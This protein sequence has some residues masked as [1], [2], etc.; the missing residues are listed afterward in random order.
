MASSSKSF[1]PELFRLQRL[2]KFPK[3]K[4]GA[5]ERSFRV[6]WCNKYPWLHYDKASD[7]AFCHLCMRAVSEGKLLA[8]TKR[9]SAFI[10][11]G[12][13]YWKE[14]TTAFKKHQASAC[15]REAHEALIMLPQQ[16][17]GDIGELLSQKHLDQKVK[18][19]EMFMKILQNLRYPAQQGLALRGSHGDFCQLFC[20]PPS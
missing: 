13:T 6:E 17:R 3:R 16:I 10:S 5:T 1:V 9:D 18:N 4:F 20:L 19:R 11:S 7:S 12:Y 15:H 14:A 2:F 8:S